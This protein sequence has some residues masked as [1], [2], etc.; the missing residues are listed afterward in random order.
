MEDILSVEH[1]FLSNK[2]VYW[3]TTK[4]ALRH[5]VS[6]V[7]RLGLLYPLLPYNENTIQTPLQVILYASM[8]NL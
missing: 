5:R 8:G 3:T 7:T 6:K 2:A 1:T 4:K